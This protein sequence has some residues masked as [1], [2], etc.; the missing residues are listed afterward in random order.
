MANPMTHYAQ[1]GRVRRHAR[2]GVALYQQS[3]FAYWSFK[4][5]GLGLQMD[6][7]DKAFRVGLCFYDSAHEPGTSWHVGICDQNNISTDK[8]SSRAAPLSFLKQ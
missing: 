5:V 6:T 3:Y 8:V 4:F 1:L 7:M 2:V